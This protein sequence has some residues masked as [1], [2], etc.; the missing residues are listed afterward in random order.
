MVF[1]LRKE[2]TSEREERNIIRNKNCMIL[3]DKESEAHKDRQKQSHRETQ[4]EIKRVKPRTR[5]IESLLKRV[6][7]V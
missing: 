4:I 2:Q 5:E 7:G 6:M 3:W 1:D